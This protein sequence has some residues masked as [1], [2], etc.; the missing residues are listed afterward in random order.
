MTDDDRRIMLPRLGAH[1]AVWGSGHFCDS[2]TAHDGPCVCD[3][4]AVRPYDPKPSDV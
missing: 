3:C 4:G 1:L 2:D